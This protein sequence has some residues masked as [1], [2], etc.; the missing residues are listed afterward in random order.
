MSIQSTLAHAG[1]KAIGSMRGRTKKPK[2]T[3]GYKL[4]DEAPRRLSSRVLL[5]D[6]QVLE[7]RARSEFEPGW[8]L[9]R[10]ALTYSTSR[11]YMRAL[12]EYTVRSKLIPRR[13]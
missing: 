4:R 6:A 2:G 13:P 8:T 3:K 10:L 1:D 9:E 12:L 5:S 11:E 7:C